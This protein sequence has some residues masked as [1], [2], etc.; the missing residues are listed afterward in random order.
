MAADF[1]ADGIRVNCLLVGTIYT[2]VAG[3]YR[4]AG[5]LSEEERERRRRAV[6]LQTEGTGWDV[7]WAAV[8]LASDEARW[9]TGAFLPV[10]GGL[11]MFHET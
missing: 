3:A 9:I 11:M 10:D 5:P 6:P 2:P 1:A 7:G 4:A 8:Y